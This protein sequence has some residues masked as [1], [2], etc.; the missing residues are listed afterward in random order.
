MDSTC[1]CFIGL[2]YYYWYYV[3]N[4]NVHHPKRK[5][6]SNKTFHP[7]EVYDAPGMEGIALSSK[8]EVVAVGDE[9][10]NEIRWSCDITGHDLNDNKETGWWIYLPV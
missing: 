5:Y 3:V 1:K 2:F 9:A 8:K 10:T 6:P 4:C 7:G